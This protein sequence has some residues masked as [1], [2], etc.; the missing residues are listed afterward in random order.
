MAQSY[1]R[2]Q[3]LDTDVTLGGGSPLDYIAASQK[4]TKTYVDN[5]LATQ[6]IV[7]VSKLVASDGS[8]DPAFSS[9]A[10]GNVTGV[11][12]GA[13][14][15]WAFVVKNTSSATA[16]AGDVGYIDS[17]GEYKTTTTA[18]LSAAWCVVLSGGANNADIYV[19]RRGRINV[20]YTGTAPSA[21]NYLVTSTSAG[22]AAQQTT[23]RPEIFAVCLAAGSG[24][25]VSVL[26]LCHTESR[27]INPSEYIFRHAAP[28]V[29]CGYSDFIG[30]IA[31]LPGG[32]V[33]TYNITSGNEDILTPYS[34]G[35]LA[36]MRLYNSTRGTYALVS[37][38]TVSTNTLTLT[39]NVPAGWTVG[40]T[41]T[42]RSQT[43]TGTNGLGYYVDYEITDTATISPLTRW[44]EGEFFYLN[45]ATA[46][47]RAII[48]PW[49]ALNIPARQMID[50]NVVSISFFRL[51]TIPIY[52]N[53][54]CASWQGNAA[55]SVIYW[56][57]KLIGV[58]AP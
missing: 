43:N 48:H 22:L 14:N 38:A 25:V 23:M 24:G 58:A 36:K 13:A 56:G 4:A 46:S 29:F 34:T 12:W 42:V 19:T 5:K 50:T 26:L 52:N 33:F 47:I 55:T 18:N 45:S 7:E 11:G 57:G 17:V 6:D 8:P 39:A 32:A 31:T 2:D 27:I 40:D 35:T 20:N 37:N 16:N 41:F 21:G 44:I 49:E 30:T 10:S 9:D 15:A 28:G 51:A 54:F 1:T 53:R 3:P